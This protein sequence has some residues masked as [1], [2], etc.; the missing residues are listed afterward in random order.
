MLTVPTFAHEP[1]YSPMADAFWEYTQDKSLRMPFCGRCGKTRWYLQEGCACGSFDTEWRELQG[2]GTVFTF[3][4]VHRCFLPDGCPKGP[5]AVGL[6]EL[7]GAAGCRMAGTIVGEA[8]PRV[9][10]RVHLD[11]H[12]CGTHMLPIF[13]ASAA[14]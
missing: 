1:G 7:D 9:G 4:I 8:D 12:D 13:T 10:M 6:I 14:G 3:T 5:Y 2:T 11:W